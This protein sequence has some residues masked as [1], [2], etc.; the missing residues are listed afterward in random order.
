MSAETV[1][2]IDDSDELRALLESIL[3]YG[4][5]R[6]ISASTVRQGLALVEKIKPDIILVDL[7]LPDGNGFDVLEALNEKKCKIPRIMMTGY[8]S[9]GVAARALRLGALGYL[10]KPFTT[11]EVL[12]NIEKALSV[13][14]LQRERDGL[15]A[16]LDLYIRH[17]ATIS[18][19]S[20]SLMA[21]IEPEQFMQR[22]VEAGQFVTRADGCLLFLKNEGT[23]QLR[24]AARRGLNA[25]FK[26][27]V[28]STAGALE[29]GV[30]L[31]EGAPVQ[32]QA[33]PG[34]SIRLQSGDEVQVVLQ[35]PLKGQ[36]QVYGL[37]SVDRRKTMAPFDSHD[38]Q[39]LMILAD[40]VALTLEKRQ[41]GQTAI[42]LPPR[43]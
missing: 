34:E 30:V 11:E 23:D 7:E 21:G 10:I 4:G 24:T 25:G 43:G 29:L 31:E 8:G 1:L 35:V 16:R 33:P 37:L 17:F 27:P 36:E 12:S 26:N 15:A 5:Y 9:E 41:Q 32:L 13:Q 19:L 3:P 40:Y 18:A 14:R 28:S 6:A 22:I 39:M 42:A 2:I 38:E 20:Q